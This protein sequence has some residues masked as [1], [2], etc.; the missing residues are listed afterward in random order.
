MT[1]QY[2]KRSFGVHQ[3]Q[4]QFD[5][6]GWRGAAEEQIPSGWGLQWIGRILNTSSDQCA[7]ARMADP[8]TA[9]PLD[10]YVTCLREF[11]QAGVA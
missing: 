9:G 8:D 2:A 3:L 7:L 6:V 1:R 10:R 4:I 5:L 11:K